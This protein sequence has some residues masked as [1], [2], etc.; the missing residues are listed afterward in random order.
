MRQADL[1]QPICILHHSE[2]ERLLSW[3]KCYPV[4]GR[5]DERKSLEHI[6]EMAISLQQDEPECGRCKR[7]Q[8][9]HPL[10]DCPKFVKRKRIIGA[11]DG[12][13]RKNTDYGPQ[14]SHRGPR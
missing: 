4:A 2:V 14:L 8:N 13:P 11:D 9:A 3:L 6:L 1:E 7:Y 5:E 12:R 10:T